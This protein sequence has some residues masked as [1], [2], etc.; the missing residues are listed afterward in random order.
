MFTAGAALA[1]CSVDEAIAPCPTESALLFK[2]TVEGAMLLPIRLPCKTG[3]DGLTTR[4]K[5][6][7]VDW[8]RFGITAQLVGGG[9]VE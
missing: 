6:G 8:F 7:T 1:A 9:F 4:P 5:E 2:E 3:L